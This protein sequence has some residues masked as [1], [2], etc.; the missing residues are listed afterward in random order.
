M[1]YDNLHLRA[2]R[3]L[4]LFL[5]HYLLVGHAVSLSFAN[6]AREDSVS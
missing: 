2:S 1:L 6:A 4:A 3:H 5:G